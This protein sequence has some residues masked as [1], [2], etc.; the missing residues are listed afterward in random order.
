MM[1]LVILEHLDILED[2]SLGFGPRSVVALLNHLLI[3]RRKDAFH[4]R[5]I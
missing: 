3:Q 4:R 5:I 1:A 2:G